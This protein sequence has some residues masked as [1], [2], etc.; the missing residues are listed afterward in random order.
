MPIKYH[1]R[2]EASSQGFIDAVP[3]S[4]YGTVLD[5]MPENGWVTTIYGHIGKQSGTP[6]NRFSIYDTSSSA[7]DDKTADTN[8][9]TPTVP[10]DSGGSGDLY[11]ALINW[12]G[13]GTG[14]PSQT[15]MKARSGV[16]FAVVAN[17]QGSGLM[18]I[19]EQFAENATNEN[20]N[21]YIDQSVAATP[22]SVFD[23]D[24]V[25]YEGQL[26]LAIGY[27]AN[28]KP[29]ATYTGDTGNITTG[30][31]TLAGTFTD[32]EETYGARMTA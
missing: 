3:G 1:G 19:G 11:Q 30:T 15:A 18:A 24:V 23:V 12:T 4:A 7:P 29:V 9:F 22:P 6:T 13:G 25:A 2:R 14:S 32:A 26:A 21:L 8:R 10:M 20:R 28:T 31:P 16:R 27:W 17:V 5:P